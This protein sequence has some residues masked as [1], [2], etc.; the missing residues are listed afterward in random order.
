MDRRESEGKMANKVVARKK[1]KVEMYVSVCKK[2][3]FPECFITRR[4]IFNNVQED[5]DCNQGFNENVNSRSRP[6]P[7]PR[8]GHPDFCN[9]VRGDTHK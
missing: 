7:R 3:E 5:R 1:I 4:Q 9:L 8:S 6:R 2:T